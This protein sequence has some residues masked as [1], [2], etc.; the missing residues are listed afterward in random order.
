MS[1]DREVVNLFA[2]VVSA[3]HHA[4]IYIATAVFLSR[5]L[6]HA[7]GEILHETD[8][9]LR[10]WQKAIQSFRT[11]SKRRFVLP[12]ER[13]SRERW[14]KDRGSASGVMEDESSHQD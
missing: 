10:K 12:R 11:R 7:V 3:L 6:R 8:F 9:E 4:W 5:V 1:I 14:P 2:A 13:R